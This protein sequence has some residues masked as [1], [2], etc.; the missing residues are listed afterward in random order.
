[1]GLRCLLWLLGPSLFY[2]IEECSIGMNETTEKAKGSWLNQTPYRILCNDVQ[3]EGAKP[4]P[5]L[6]SGLFCS[7]PLHKIWYGI[8]SNALPAVP[9]DWV[10]NARWNCSSL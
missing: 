10:I 6:T 3:Q 1:M 2:T 7:V 9:P 5:D 4:R 8:L